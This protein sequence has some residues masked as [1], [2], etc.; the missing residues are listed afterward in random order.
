MGTVIIAVTVIDSIMGSGKTSWAIQ[1]I[2]ESS[3]EQKFI[4][5]TPFL[6]EIE[7]II[8]KSDRHFEQPNH[9][10]SEGTKLQSLKGLIADGYN[11]AATHSLFKTAD[12]ELIE[13]LQQSDYTLILDEVMDVVNQAD[14]KEYDIRA[15]MKSHY[16]EI[17]NNRV[18]WGYDG[19]VDGRFLDIKLLANAGN[20]FY[21]RDRFLIW[22]FPPSVFRAFKDVTVMTY[23]FAAQLQRYYFDLYDINYEYKSVIKVGQF[24]KLTDYEK[25]GEPRQHVMALIDLYEGDLNDIGEDKN[26]LSTT[27]LRNYTDNVLDRIQKNI[28]NYFRRKVGAKRHDII[29]TT[30]KTRQ[31]DLSGG[32][33]ARSFIPTNTRATNDYADTWALAYVFNRF[34]SPIEHSFF[35]DNGISVNQDLLAVS[36][37][38]QWVWRSRIRK[39]EPIKLYLPSSRMRG[40]LLSWSK[41]EI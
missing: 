29:W 24:Y 19:Y 5:I 37:L 20:L 11:I 27:K 13:L 33:Y 23:L 8:E 10:N 32:G 14:I 38:L 17:E 1:H 34:M 39:G 12:D 2:N 31:S 7:R 9:N 16:I 15:L 40:L 35:E 41:F 6:K 18:R 21:H 25:V 36:D 26:A 4:Y 22:A 30:L 3:R 28:Y